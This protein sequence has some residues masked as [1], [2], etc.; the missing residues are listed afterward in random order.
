MKVNSKQCAECA[1]GPNSPFSAPIKAAMLRKAKDGTPSTCHWNPKTSLSALGGATI[2]E[3]ARCFAGV[4]AML[5]NLDFIDV[6]DCEKDLIRKAAKKLEFV[7]CH[8]A[9]SLPL[10]L[11]EAKI[12]DI[13]AEVGIVVEK[14]KLRILGIA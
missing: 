6:P 4:Q 10:K 7:E 1:L 9:K 8:S 3:R 12:C 14:A 2:S 13:E 5:A 11:G